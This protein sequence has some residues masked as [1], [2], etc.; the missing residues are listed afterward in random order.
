MCKKDTFFIVA[1]KKSEGL[2]LN[3]PQSL[4][5]S[6]VEGQAIWGSSKHGL[7]SYGVLMREGQSIAPCYASLARGY[8]CVIPSE[9]K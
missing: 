9:L 5:L 3:N 1:S 2:N 4:T 6:E 8:P 7:N